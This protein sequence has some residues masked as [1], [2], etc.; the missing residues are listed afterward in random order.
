MPNLYIGI[1]SGTSMDSIDTVLF[2]ANLHK[3]LFAITTEFPPL[4]RSRL[5]QIIAKERCI[6][7]EIGEL[8]AILGIEFAKCAN[9]LLDKAHY[10]VDDI[11]AIG[12]HGQTLYHSPKSEYPFTWQIGDPN[13]V[14]AITGITTVADFRRMDV[15]L[16]GQGAPLLPSF[17]A[18]LFSNKSENRVVLNLG[19]ISNITVLG[20]SSD[21]I[22]G[23]DCGPAN[24]LLDSWIEHNTGYG[25][26]N[27]GQWARSGKVDRNLLSL[28]LN[29]PYFSLPY[30]KSTGR[31]YFNQQWIDGYIWKTANKP[32]TSDVQRTLTELTV[33]SIQ[34]AINSLQPGT[35]RLIICGGGT[36]NTFLI[37]RLKQQLKGV[38][39]E[40]TLAYNI[41]PQHI[42]PSAFAWF[43]HCALNGIP[44]NLPSVTGA[45]R[46]AISGAIYQPN[47]IQYPNIAR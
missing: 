24:C 29:D 18:M 12:V 40:N 44:I 25:F 37:E 15:A 3:L 32:S 26:D 27:E 39:I 38:T 11:A 23:M 13:R 21:T 14:A 43:A 33:I 35:D 46:R 22:L 9:N 4:V 10:K 7:D 5:L 42:E 47:K 17:H 6:L 28:M 30:P 20:S 19:G 36:K 31:E 34:K 16:G 41:D 1:N 2:D 45:S 8:D